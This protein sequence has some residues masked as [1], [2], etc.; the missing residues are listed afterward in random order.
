MDGVRVPS[1]KDIAFQARPDTPE[2]NCCSVNGPRGFG[3]L[4]EWAVMLSDAGLV[5]DFYGSGAFHG[6]LQDK[7]PITLRWETDYPLSGQVRLSLELETPRRFPLQLRI[8]AWSLNTSLSVTNGDRTETP[9]ATAGT[10]ITLDREWRN[11]DVITLDFD[12]NLRAVAGEGAAAGKVSIYRG[13]LLLAYDPHYNRLSEESLPPLSLSRLSE[14]TVVNLE[15]HSVQEG[16][17]GVPWLLVDVPT[18]DG[19]TLRL[20][21]YASAGATGTSYNSWL[22]ADPENP[23][24]TT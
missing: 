17:A 23:L 12:M 15:D 24:Q 19:Q 11:G 6:Q 22:K 10:Y 4:S 20:C 14:G 3:M 8:P 16:P 7:T 2:L 5:V 21:D 13:P 18:T 1:Y 9:K